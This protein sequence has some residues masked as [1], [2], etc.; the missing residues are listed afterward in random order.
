[1][2]RI[3]SYIAIA[4]LSKPQHDPRYAI[5]YSRPNA[6]N[7]SA[8]CWYWT[9]HRHGITSLIPQR[10][11]MPSHG[12]T[13]RPVLHP[14]TRLYIQP[15]RGSRGTATESAPP[16]ARP[17][18]TRREGATPSCT[19]R[20]PNADWLHRMVPSTATSTSVGCSRTGTTPSGSRDAGKPHHMAIT[21]QTR[22]ILGPQSDLQDC[23][24]TASWSG[25]PWLM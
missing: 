8:Q 12:A 20:D 4:L 2:V 9:A 16:L 22:A 14:A 19:R 5:C 24:A 7:S 10:K 11:N 17:S 1:M 13:F 23:Q 18:S 21:D 6:R 3:M 25:W 15:S